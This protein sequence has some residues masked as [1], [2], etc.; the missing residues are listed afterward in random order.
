M[1]CSSSGVTGVD[2]GDA[3]ALCDDVRPVAVGRRP[4]ESD[5]LARFCLGDVDSAARGGTAAGRG[6]DPEAHERTSDDGPERVVAHL[7][8]DRRPVAEPGAA[9]A[10]F[11]ALPPRN[12]RNDVTSSNFEPMCSA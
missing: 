6:R 10:T 7:G 4:D 3:G 12:Y 1:I 2:L 11:V 9:T 5:R 8:H